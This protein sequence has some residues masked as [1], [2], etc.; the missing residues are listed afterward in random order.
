MHSS[1]ESFNP[2]SLPSRLDTM[3]D[4]AFHAPGIGVFGWGADPLFTR[5]NHVDARAASL[6]RHV[7]SLGLATRLRVP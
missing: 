4:I 2:P 5:N 6:I 3:D 7:P 1:F